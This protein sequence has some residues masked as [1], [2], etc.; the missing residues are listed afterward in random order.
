[1]QLHRWCSTSGMTGIRGRL[2]SASGASVYS[3]QLQTYPRCLRHNMQDHPT[4]QHKTWNSC[5]HASARLLTS[6]AAAFAFFFCCFHSGSLEACETLHPQPETR[7]VIA[8][9]SLPIPDPPTFA[10]FKYHDVRTPF[11]W[12]RDP[13]WPGSLQLAR[14]DA[15]GVDGRVRQPRVLARRAA[16]VEDPVDAVGDGELDPRPALGVGQRR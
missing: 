10:C 12:F 3:L 2:R 6:V 1:M 15:P 5:T 16:G 14:V 7:P 8:G 13:L 9:T 4:A 11:K